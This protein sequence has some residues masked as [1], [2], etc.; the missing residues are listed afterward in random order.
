MLPLLGAVLSLLLG[1]VLCPLLPNNRRRAL[2]GIAT[3]VTACALVLLTVLPIIGGDNDTVGH[4]TWSYPVDLIAVRIDG[5]AAFFLAFSLPIITLGSIYAYGY[6]QPMFAS[7][8]NVGVHYSLLNLLALAFVVIYTVENALVFLLGW[9]MTAIAAW[10][11]IIWDYHDQKNPLCRLQL[12]GRHPHRPDL[13][14]RG[15]FDLVQSNAI[16]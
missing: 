7:E 12:S 11:L 3:Q 8:R 4:L 15:V 10:L 14:D 16:L 9:E 13:C 1:V 6:M 5:L 2:V